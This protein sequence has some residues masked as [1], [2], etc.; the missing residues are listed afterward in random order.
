MDS[1]TILVAV[2]DDELIYRKLLI[3]KLT[4]NG[5]VVILEAE[6]GCDFLLQLHSKRFLP[7]IVIMDIEM[8]VM[9]GF[10]TISRLKSQWKGIKVV[11]HSSLCDEETI[12]RVQSCGADLFVAK[13]DRSNGL[14]EAIL[15]LLGDGLV[16]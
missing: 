2:V 1:K 14:T 4:Q 6:H 3:R 15:S 9:D 10:Q 8:P 12:N 7:Q 11:A 16:L 13:P 5:M